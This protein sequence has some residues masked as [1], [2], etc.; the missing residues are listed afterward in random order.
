MVGYRYD[1]STTTAN[2]LWN[3]GSNTFVGGGYVQNA[4]SARNRD[5]YKQRRMCLYYFVADAGYFI[6][7]S[8]GYTYNGW[9][10]F[11]DSTARVYAY[12]ANSCP[13]N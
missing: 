13:P 10:T 3:T 1:V 9:Y 11:S 4:K 8:L 5:S 12:Y 7:T 6:H 2:L